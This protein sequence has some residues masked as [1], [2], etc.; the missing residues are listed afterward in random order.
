MHSPLYHLYVGI[1]CNFFCISTN[2]SMYVCMEGW[3]GM[4][5]YFC[6]CVMH[7]QKYVCATL[8]CPTSNA[9]HF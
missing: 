2:K 4:C 7:A 3:M 6:A 9:M 5:A 8:R 1:M